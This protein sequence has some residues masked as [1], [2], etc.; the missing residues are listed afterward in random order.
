MLNEDQLGSDTL[1]LQDKR[2]IF[3]SM[4]DG[5]MMDVGAKYDTS[6]LGLEEIRKSTK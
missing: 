5:P 4:D 3:E 2:G 1:P 6:G